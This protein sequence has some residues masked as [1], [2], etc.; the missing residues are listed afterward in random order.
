MSR[1]SS[2][3]IA[4][5]L[6]VLAGCRK[7][8]AV[9]ASLNVANKVAVRTV[10]L[11]FEG[12]EMLLAAETRDVAVPENPAG[13]I[14]VV[15]RELLEGPANT[16]VPPLLPRDSVLRGA[17]LLPDGTAIVDLGGPTLT[18]G[19]GAGSHQELMAIYSIVQTV[20][21]N[22]P[23]ARRVRVLV[24][25]SPAETLGGHVSLARS[26]TPAPGVLARR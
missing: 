9:P 16:A 25:G 21:T 26:I 6:V 11:F 12:P 3:A 14:P 20:V 18:N 22:F 19:W 2:L 17:Y 13:A 15:M 23:E 7:T 8:P 24:N 4:I 1:V 10:S 5:T